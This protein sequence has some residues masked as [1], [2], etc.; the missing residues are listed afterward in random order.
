MIFV[1][2]VWMTTMADRFEILS[3]RAADG[4]AR[5]VLAL[6]SER[7]GEKTP[8]DRA[9]TLTFADFMLYYNRLLYIIFAVSAIGEA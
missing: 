6:E 9:Y 1:L 7:G 2:L 5:L 8:K 3:V 4:G